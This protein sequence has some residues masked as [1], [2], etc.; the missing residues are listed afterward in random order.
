MVLY[1][2]AVKSDNPTKYVLRHIKV[3]WQ[4][5]DR[6]FIKRSNKENEGEKLRW[7]KK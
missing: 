7:L 4:R 1:S 5:V 2:R 3:F 6:E